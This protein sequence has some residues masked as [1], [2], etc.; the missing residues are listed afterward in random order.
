[1]YAHGK[2]TIYTINFALDQQNLYIRAEMDSD[3]I[4]PIPILKGHPA[5]SEITKPL[6]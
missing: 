2:T 1:M 6:L 3:F 5:D 4:N